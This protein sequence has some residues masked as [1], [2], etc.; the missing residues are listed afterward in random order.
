MIE[1]LYNDQTTMMHKMYNRRQMTTEKL[2]LTD[3]YWKRFS[4]VIYLLISKPTSREFEFEWSQ[5]K[6]PYIYTA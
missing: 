2:K 3:W 5:I 6:F 1:K 4:V